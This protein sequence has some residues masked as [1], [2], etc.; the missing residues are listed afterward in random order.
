MTLADDLYEA[1][2]NEVTPDEFTQAGEPMLR[3]IADACA[4][5][6]HAGTGPDREVNYLPVPPDLV[7][8]RARF[9]AAGDYVWRQDFAFDVIATV[10]VGDQ[11][12][13]LITYTDGDL[14][15][16]SPVGYRQIAKDRGKAEVWN[17]ER[18]LFDAATL[19]ALQETY[20]Y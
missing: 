15:V 9:L 16:L 19:A 12:S 1:V 4:R 17:L 5:A 11:G 8:V 7:L 10:S 14:E 6:V 20:S 2:L 13:V 3:R 18:V